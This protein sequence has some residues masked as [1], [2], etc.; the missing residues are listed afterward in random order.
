[1]KVWDYLN[2]QAVEVVEVDG[3]KV[4]E[5]HDNDMIELENGTWLKSLRDG[6]FTDENG[7]A[8]GRAYDEIGEDEFVSCDIF[9]KL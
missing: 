7:A 8:W 9:F 5:Q 2:D 1:M 6:R 4:K 3:V